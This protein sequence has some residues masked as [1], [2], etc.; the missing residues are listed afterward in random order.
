MIRFLIID[1]CYSYCG[2]DCPQQRE[3][4]MHQVV[5]TDEPTT[6][7]VSFHLDELDND[8]VVNQLQF[9]LLCYYF[10]HC[11]SWILR[12][13]DVRLQQPSSISNILV[14]SDLLS[15][16]LGNFPIKAFTIIDIILEPENKLGREI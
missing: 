15:L 12:Q 11:R 4:N 5:E 8:R 14:K 1:V 13:S 16:W 6:E 10:D 2:S 3:Q 7:V 9:F